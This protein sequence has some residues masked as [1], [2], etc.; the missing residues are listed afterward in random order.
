MSLM[1]KTFSWA[2]KVLRA[3][4]VPNR[5]KTRSPQQLELLQAVD[6]INAV[7]NSGP[8]DVP[9]KPL[10]FDRM[11]TLDFFFSEGLA[12]IK[13]RPTEKLIK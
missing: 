5:S 7:E 12:I 8:I 1:K 11:E 6:C 13:T 3:S 2:S 4:L 9:S 10:T